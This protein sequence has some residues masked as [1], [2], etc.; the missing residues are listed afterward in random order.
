[1]A[2]ELRALYCSLEGTD[3]RV[4]ERTVLVPP[5][6]KCGPVVH[7]YLNV[8]KPGA[9]LVAIFTELDAT[10][11]E[12]Y[13]FIPHLVPLNEHGVH[14]YGR[15]KPLPNQPTDSIFYSTL[16]PMISWCLTNNFNI[17]LVPGDI[18]SYQ[19]SPR[20]NVPAVLA[21]AASCIQAACL[22]GSVAPVRIVYVTM[23]PDVQKLLKKDRE[24]GPYEDLQ[25]SP[26]Y[27]DGT[28]DPSHLVG[29]HCSCAAAMVSVNYRMVD[30][31][32]HQHD[33]GG[34]R[35]RKKLFLEIQERILNFLGALRTTTP[36]QV[37]LPVP[38]QTVPEQAHRQ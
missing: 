19:D 4:V 26:R 10:V 3:P 36:R 9:P 30:R 22:P 7:Y 6:P 11:F 34:A 28:A 1:M 31:Q 35:N 20:S 5:S 29:C 33:G 27:V 17:A 15:L 32:D 16:L 18:L 8:F 25:A 13:K 23:G 12:N 38:P 21:D 24:S 14:V 37:Q 2:I